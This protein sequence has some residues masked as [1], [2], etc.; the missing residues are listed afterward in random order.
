MNLQ[1][2]E[3]NFIKRL[4]LDK[5]NESEDEG[6]EEFFTQLDENSFKGKEYKAKKKKWARFCLAFI[7]LPRWRKIFR[8]LPKELKFNQLEP[9]EF[10]EVALD[11]FV[12]VA[13]KMKSR[14][15]QEKSSSISEK[16]ENRSDESRKDLK[17]NILSTNSAEATGQN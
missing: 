10:Q 13:E 8:L 6:Y 12:F 17:E 7:D 16:T 3:F 4:T 2:K 1:G 11:F 5:I 14:N 15:G 9:V